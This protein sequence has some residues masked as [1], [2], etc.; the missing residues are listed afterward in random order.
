MDMCKCFGN[1]C[2]K[3][4]KCYRYRGRSSNWQPFAD[5]KQNKDG[6]CN[7]FIK[8]IKNYDKIK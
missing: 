6:S 5:F 7:Y 2:T 4:N 8:Y 3:K 1:N